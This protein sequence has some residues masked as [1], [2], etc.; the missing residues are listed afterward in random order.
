MIGDAIND[1]VNKYIG[2]DYVA[3]NISEWA[4]PISKPTSTPSD[5][6]GMREIDELE[7]FIKDQAKAEAET[8]ITAT[9]GEFMGEDDDDADRAGTPRACRAGR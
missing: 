7:H 9:L 2:K 4:E 6:R 1:A 5:F 3:A 8:N